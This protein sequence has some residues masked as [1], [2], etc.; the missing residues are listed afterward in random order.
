MHPWEDWAETWAHYLHMVETLGTARS[1]GMALR[2]QPQGGAAPRSLRFRS[3]Q[4]SFDDFDDLIAGWVPLTVALNC[5]N[6]AMG[7]PDCYPFVLSPV[8]I[9]KLRFVHDVIE[10]SCRSE[11]ELVASKSA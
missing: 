4:L 6:R 11:V 8:A 9:S 1:Y 5:T 3:T 10:R 7:L 2:P